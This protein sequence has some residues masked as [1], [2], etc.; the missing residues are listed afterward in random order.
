MKSISQI[1]IAIL[2]VG[3]AIVSGSILA[4][5][6]SDLIKSYQ[7]SQ[8]MISRIGRV[9]VELHS[10]QSSGNY[11]FT[12]STKLSN[13]G[14]TPYTVPDG[15]IV[16][17]VKG[18]TGQGRILKCSLSESETIMPGEIKTISATCSLSPGELEELFGETTPPA[19]E[20]KQA[21]RYLYMYLY[22]YTS[23]QGGTSGRPPKH[24]LIL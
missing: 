10:I 2:L 16:V 1:I 6:V 23:S 20:V 5:M 3:V 21:F 12:V 19:D 15:W 18:S 17:L 9:E 11:W 7:P 8:V 24:I 22:V 4:Y 14:T 13:L